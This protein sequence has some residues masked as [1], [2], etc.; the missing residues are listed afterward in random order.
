MAAFLEGGFTC[1]TQL[2]AQTAD[3]LSSYLYIK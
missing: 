1:V 2:I 3:I